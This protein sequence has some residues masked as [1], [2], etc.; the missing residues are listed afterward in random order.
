ML[1]GRP[2]KIIWK[3]LCSPLFEIPEEDPDMEVQCGG[4]ALH[5]ITKIPYKDLK[6]LGKDGHWS[7]RLMLSFLRKK[8]YKVIPITIG[9]TVDAHDYDGPIKPELS[10]MHVILL[11]QRS[12][13][14]SNTW[15]VLFNGIRYHSG[16]VLEVNG[17]TFL[18]YP[19]VAAYLIYHPKWSANKNKKNIKI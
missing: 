18:N 16:E 9:N 5:A 14:Y 4:Y 3:D 17:T 7:T 13:R 2:Q 11:E 19:I 15:S 6:H 12:Y 1:K 10:N 8:N